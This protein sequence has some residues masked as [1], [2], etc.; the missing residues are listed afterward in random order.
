MQN[1]N[2]RIGICEC[3][4]HYHGEL[5]GS[6]VQIGAIPEEGFGEPVFLVLSEQVI[7]EKKQQKNLR[8][9]QPHLF[10]DAHGGVDRDWKEQYFV[11]VSALQRIDSQAGPYMRSVFYGERSWSGALPTSQEVVGAI[12]NIVSTMKRRMKKERWEA[13]LSL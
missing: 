11:R 7:P 5:R 4:P 1:Q 6:Q 2:I 3:T 12:Q 13:W 9:L 10:L 8:E